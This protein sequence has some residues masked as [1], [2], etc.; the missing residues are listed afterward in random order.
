MLIELLILSIKLPS[1]LV[2]L[3]PFPFPS[4]A[5]PDRFPTTTHGY[6]RQLVPCPYHPTVSSKYNVHF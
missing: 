3:D 4:L 5:A 1:N 6:P 2:P